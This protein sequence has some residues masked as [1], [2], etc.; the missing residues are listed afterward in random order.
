MPECIAKNRNCFGDVKMSIFTAE[1]PIDVN[2]EHNPWT[3]QG[4]RCAY[5]R[6]FWYTVIEKD[7]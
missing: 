1:H 3:V 2:P 7:A 4:Y 5:H 6:G